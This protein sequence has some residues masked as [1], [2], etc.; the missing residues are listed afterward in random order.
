MSHRLTLALIVLA[1]TAL[2][3]CKHLYAGGDAGRL[4]ATPAAEAQTLNRS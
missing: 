2:A 4:H 3:G 1:A